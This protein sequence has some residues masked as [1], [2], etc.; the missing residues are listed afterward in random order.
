MT[1]ATAILDLAQS[2]GAEHA[3]ADLAILGTIAACNYI[4]QPAWDDLCQR[5]GMPGL[6]GYGAESHDVRRAYAAGWNSVV[7]G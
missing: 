2:I 7:E 1:T 6:Y 3:T 4:S 5:I